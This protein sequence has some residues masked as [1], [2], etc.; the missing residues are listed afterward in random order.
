[1]S[2]ERIRKTLARGFA[3]ANRWVVLGT[4]TAAVLTMTGILMF[5][6]DG[7]GAD[8]AVPAAPAQPDDG[9]VARSQTG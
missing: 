9:A 7:S 2:D 6:T 1:M 3:P 5:A 8:P 4:G